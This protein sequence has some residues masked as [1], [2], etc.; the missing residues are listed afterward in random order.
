MTTLDLRE[1]LFEFPVGWERAEVQYFRQVLAI[2]QTFFQSVPCEVEIGKLREL[3]MLF[4]INRRP[5]P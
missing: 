3:A 4:S 1:Q 5:F 2:P